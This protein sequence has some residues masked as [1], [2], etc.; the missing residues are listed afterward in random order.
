M[1]AIR[2]K[3][4]QS[5]AAFRKPTS[6]GIKE[7]Y[8][9]P[10]YSTVIG[11]INTA[12]GIKCFTDMSISVQGLFSSINQELIT[13]YHYK[14]GAK[15][16][17]KKT[18]EEIKKTGNK[19][20]SAARHQIYHEV[21]GIKYGVT[22]TP[23][24]VEK[25][26]DLELILHIVPK[27]DEDVDFLYK[28]LRDPKNIPAIGR[29]EDLFNIHEVSIQ[30]L[31]VLDEDDE[32]YGVDITKYDAYLPMSEELRGELG[33]VY[34]TYFRLNKIY[35]VMGNARRWIEKVEALYLS[36]GNETFVTVIDE[37]NIPVYLG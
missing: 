26:I 2:I 28:N 30:E 29:S 13:E 15:F 37:D 19:K 23:T 7:T 27:N 5:S 31:K 3:G 14:Q 35:E 18:E 22:K 32:D 4:Y 17:G 16:E 10:P 25:V 1:R 12:C 36:E 24:I 33:N 34:G 8:P 21:E 9:L 11:F 6:Y 20:G